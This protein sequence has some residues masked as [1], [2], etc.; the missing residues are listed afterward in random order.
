MRRK[1]G[2]GIVAVFMG[3]ACA[4]ARGG[5]VPGMTATNAT[6]RVAADT[7][8]DRRVVVTNAPRPHGSC[9]SLAALAAALRQ[10]GED[11]T[12]T[13]LQGVGAFAFRLQFS[14]CPSAP[15]AQVGY[16][17]VIPTLAAVGYAATRHPGTLADTGDPAVRWRPATAAELA[18]TRVAVKSAIDAGDTV[19]Y[20][21]EEDG[22]LVGYEPISERNQSGWLCRP[23]PLGPPPKPGEPYA[24][25]I[26]R[27]PWGIGILRKI[28]PPQPRADAALA[29]LRAAVDN[30][31]RGTVAGGDLKTGFA[32]W[33][34]WI[35]EL[36][37]APFQAMVVETQGQLVERG[38]GG[39]DAIRN[40]CLGNAWT[41][42]NLFFARLE[43]ARYLRDV[44][45]DL[46]VS[47]RPHLL[48]AADAY[49]RVHHAL[50]P[51]GKCFMD[52]A[53]YPFMLKQ[54][55][56]EWNDESRAR[57]AA[58]LGAALVHERA[59]VAALEQAL[60]TR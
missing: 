49:E 17:C 47:M 10:R 56:I 35:H 24:Q 15:H 30:A 45:D 44:A 5:E 6:A 36:E 4:L 46:P 37:P 38:R 59:A 34:K 31:W 28:G 43:A 54:I 1:Q 23:G 48:A 50:V 14:W 7:V 57:Q 58:L 20:G 60:A 32:A 39:E 52:V 3:V 16:D 22:L 11:V 26:K 33:E 42:E 19:I 41:Y 51:E 2:F 9:S 25:P 40:I 18:A 21:S 12:F 55:A 53:P 8:Y 13:Y 29:A 27:V